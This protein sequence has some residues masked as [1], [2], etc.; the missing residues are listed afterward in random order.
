MSQTLTAFTAGDLVVSLSGDGD[1]SGT[2]GDNQAS[3]ITLEEL[4]K[5]GAIVGTLVLPQA[6]TPANGTT[7]YA[8]SGEYGSSSEGTLQLSADGQSL[9]IGGYGVNAASYNAAE[10]AGG[11]NIYGNAA[12]AQ[13]TSLTSQ[14]TYTPVARV[15]ADIRA[16]GTVDTST[17]LY[18]IDNTNNIRSVATVN[19]TTFYVSGQGVKGDTTQGLF[20]AADGASSATP[21]DTST[22]TRQVEIYNGVLYVSRDSKQQGVGGTSKGTSNIATYGT[23]PTSTTTD[24][25]L[26]GISQSV[27]L[28]AAQEN[29]VDSSLVG[30]TTYLSPE[31][32][33]FANATTL[34]VADS[35]NPKL[36]GLGD[37]GLQKW[38]YNGSSWVLDY[39][40]SQGLNLV[41]DTG[42]SGTTGLIGLT[43]SVSGNT[44]TLYATNSTIG[45][46]D[47]TFLYGITDTLS[48]TTTPANETFTQLFAAPADTN[49]RGIAFAP[50]AVACYCRGTHILT[51][52]GEVAVESLQAGDLV[53]TFTGQGAVLKPIRWLGHRRIDLRRHPDPENTHPIR[54]RAG[55]L[56]AGVPHRDLLVSP[57]HRM[58]VGNTLVT[59]LELANG[60]SIA[61]ESPA[62]VEYWHIELEG[63]DVILAEGVEAETYQDVG[64]RDAFENSA[65][66]ALN[67]ILDGNVPN[68]CLPYAGASSA[69]RACLMTR[70]EALG[71]TQTI[72][73]APWLEVDGKRIEP[74]RY[75]E[76]YR[77]T[78]PAHR[79]AVRLRSRAVRPWHVDPQSGDRRQLGLKLYRLALHLGTGLRVVDLDSPRL[80][81]GFNQVER[82]SEGR[83]CR[84]TNGDAL[85]PLRELA[86]GQTV[87]V[88]EIAY[89]QALP[90]WIEPDTIHVAGSAEAAGLNTAA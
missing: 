2:Y 83:R 33:F 75:G 10:G 47:P 67:P 37:G 39:T 52:C 32:Y 66:V 17:A 72:D 44:V 60:A 45:D 87:V 6:A 15:V 55:A 25:P 49:V 43:G 82:D 18:N 42:T 8:I 65:V 28:T 21:I 3:P 79:G 4:T 48:A 22:D 31:S 63:H 85:L 68:P 71:W 69:T 58:R 11:S 54:F 14:S 57:N 12:L 59:A 84:W 26:T 77:F 5:T 40:L 13:S 23:E 89:D 51:R 27:T 76:G 35:G 74:T 88:I 64:N 90:M 16:N 19:G 70:A 24:V 78:L 9:V 46:L 41:A 38:T 81:Q 29:T 56:A 34:Y 53:V 61:Q 62:E 30:K 36:G 1:G 80:G 20:V 7:E 50:V 73:P 86:F